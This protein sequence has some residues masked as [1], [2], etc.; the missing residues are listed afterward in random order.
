MND[1]S[2]FGGTKETLIGHSKSL[3]TVGRRLMALRPCP[4]VNWKKKRRKR[5]VTSVWHF[6]ISRLSLLDA[7]NSSD[8]ALPDALSVGRHFLLQLLFFLASPLHLYFSLSSRSTL[9]KKHTCVYIQNK[10]R[11]TSTNIDEHRMRTKRR[12]NFHPFSL[13]TF[14]LLVFALFLRRVQSLNRSLFG[15]FASKIELSESF[16]FRQTIHH[17]TDSSCRPQR[18]N[19]S[20][21]NLFLKQPKSCVRL[22]GWMEGK[23]LEL[24][25]CFGWFSVTSWLKCL[26]KFGEFVFF[27]CR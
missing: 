22:C 21:I 24:L 12:S 4:Q 11:Q 9:V 8:C 15:F 2:K 5:S 3:P 14:A 18:N 27:V 1:R 16:H 17:I 26:A 7:N 19:L 6:L 10:H 13:E 23:S 25:M 20:W